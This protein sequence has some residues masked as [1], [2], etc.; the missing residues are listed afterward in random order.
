MAEFDVLSY[1]ENCSFFYILLFYIMLCFI[2]S[3]VFR[4]AH[5][6]AS[7]DF[8]TVFIAFSKMEER[9]LKIRGVLT[10]FT[11]EEFSVPNL[12]NM[13]LA[14]VSHL[15]YQ[16]RIVNP[17]HLATQPHH[18]NNLTVT[19]LTEFE[20]F[21]DII[22]FISI[23]QP[24]STRE[25][26]S[27]SKRFSLRGTLDSQITTLSVMRISDPAKSMLLYKLGDDLVQLAQTGQ[28]RKIVQY[29]N[30]TDDDDILFY[31]VVKM[32]H[33]AL[34]NGHLMIAT[35]IIDQGYPLHNPIIPNSLLDAINVVD[36]SLALTIIEFL[37]LA[38]G[39]DINSQVL[40]LE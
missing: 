20:H 2:L 29:V 28:L 31:F 33:S 22:S 17:T 40:V 21:R 25:M 36:D 4:D 39:M 38:N 11:A 16:F 9:N 34:I 37:V 15:V 14:S 6:T 1:L 18:L 19:I 5:N 8:P 26:F 30:T 12:R 10:Y 7:L 35:F 27:K 24:S 13:D 32:M 3:T 23:L